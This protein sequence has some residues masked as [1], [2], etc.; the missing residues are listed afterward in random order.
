MKFSDRSILEYIE[1][2][3]INNPE[4]IAIIKNDSYISYKELWKEALKVSSHIQELNIRK[5]STIA[6]I[7]EEIENALPTIIGIIHAGCIYIPI[8]PTA[9][10]FNI[11]YMIDVGKVK[12]AIVDCDNNYCKENNIEYV[13]YY[14]IDEGKNHYDSRYFPVAYIMLH[15]DQLENLKA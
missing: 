1:R 8:S 10:S 12:Y 2:N 5:G 15:Q 14:N 11:K 6:V 7:Q 3:V 4:K 9:S 13:S